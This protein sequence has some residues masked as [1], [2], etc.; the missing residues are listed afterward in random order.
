ML[1]IAALTL[2]ILSGCSQSQ[3]TAELQGE[4]KEL[5]S[6]VAALRAETKDL[7]KATEKSAERELSRIEEALENTP[8]LLPA[9]NGYTVVESDIGHLAMRIVD[10]QPFGAGSR[11]TLEIGNTTAATLT[12]V[13]AE[14]RWGSMD[15]DNKPVARASKS[16]SIRLD[17]ALP[18]GKWTRTSVVLEGVSP[19]DFGYLEVSEVQHSSV[20]LRRK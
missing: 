15:K 14:L 5:R 11:V 18:A 16:R 12:G 10:V 7:R 13:S 1:K 20:Q 9:A 6:E 2:M 4:V 3:D 19:A 8:R 17:D